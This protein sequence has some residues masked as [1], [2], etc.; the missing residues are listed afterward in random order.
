MTSTESDVV[1]LL[2]P[3][4]GFGID[5][6][7]SYSANSN[8]LTPS[9]GFEFTLANDAL[10]DTI[11]DALKRGEEFRII[12][13]GNTQAEGFIDKVTTESSRNG[14][15]ILRVEGCDKLA[16]VVRAGIDPR[17]RFSNNVTL[18]DILKK[19]FAPFGY[20]E[21]N[22]LVSNDVNRGVLQGQVR[23][24]R[25]TKGGKKKGPRPVKSFT[26]HQTKPY[27]GEGTFAFASRLTQRHGLWI[28]LSAIGNQLII[29]RPNFTQ[30]ASYHLFDKG[31]PETNILHGTAREDSSQQPSCI[32]ATGYSYGGE[33]DRSHLKVIVVNEIV[34]LG[35]DGFA[36]PAVSKIIADNPDA[37][38]LPP[39][40]IFPPEAIRAHAN[41]QPLYLH[42]Q[43]SQTLEQ[44]QNYARRELALRQKDSLHVTY[45]VPGHEQN[46]T[47]WAVDAIV[48]VDDDARGI[49]EP[50][51]ILSRTFEKSREGTF[52][53]LECIRRFTMALGG[54]DD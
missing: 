37:C 13:N 20:T 3:K 10:D 54:E 5:K 36:T 22:M 2:F 16:Q 49:H 30:P 43:E 9:D 44:L 33:A 40:T 45:T 52:T 14:G 24:Q 8:F 50:L 17:V 27:P 51:W 29:S 11:R 7:L 48:D 26:L 38:Q 4:Y 21:E 35:P 19:L 42:D 23:G 28:W 34:G 31:G 53:R 1:E 47:V 18:L 6:W 39:R 32:V 25:L 46:G 41:A 12:V 15:T